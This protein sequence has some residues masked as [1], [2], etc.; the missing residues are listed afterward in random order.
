[1]ISVVLARACV[2]VVGWV[3]HVLS[4]R[5]TVGVSR[6]C[7]VCVVGEEESIPG[8]VL[9]IVF[10]L[11]VAETLI[12]CLVHGPLSDVH[13]L[14]RDHSG[15]WPKVRSLIPRVALLVLVGSQHG[16]GKS[17]EQA[18]PNEPPTEG[19][20]G[21]ISRINVREVVNEP[22]NRDDG[23]TALVPLGASTD[24]HREGGGKN[25]TENHVVH[26]GELILVL[27]VLLVLPWPPLRAGHVFPEAGR[28]PSVA[29]ELVVQPVNS[30]K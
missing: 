9:A 20:S 15:E 22:L 27:N 10:P 17:T 14:L 24:E 23:D 5:E 16:E 1:M 2:V 19:L 3:V 29:Q 26:K 8:A 25:R 12:V 21:V 28:H 7:V 6:D 30:M 4:M 18:C 13:R 11:L